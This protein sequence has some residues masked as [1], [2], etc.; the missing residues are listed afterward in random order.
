M[1][2]ARVS[3]QERENN[4]T[5]RE[6]VVHLSTSL[7]LGLLSLRDLSLCIDLILKLALLRH[8]VEFPLLLLELLLFL[9][10]HVGQQGFFG[11]LVQVAV[12]GADD[13]VGVVDGDGADVG[14]GLDLGCAEL[15]LGVCHCEGELF[16]AR[17]DGVPAG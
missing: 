13:G 15:D 12:E 2:K 16:H 7:S 8:T 3:E 9:V 17:L 1:M 4:Q 11:F 10:G 5:R 14:E 6:A